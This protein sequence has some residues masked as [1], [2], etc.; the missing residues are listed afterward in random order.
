MTPHPP[1]QNPPPSARRQ[2]R[3][4]VHAGPQPAS[5]TPKRPATRRNRRRLVAVLAAA[6]VVAAGCSIKP[7][8]TV[9]A[10]DDPAPGGAAGGLGDDAKTPSPDTTAPAGPGGQAE[11][12][13]QTIDPQPGGPGG[14]QAGG[15]DSGSEQPSEGGP[16]TENGDGD[17][18]GPVAQTG[19]LIP[20]DDVPFW[21]LVTGRAVR[22]QDGNIT[23]PGGKYG[24]F[25][26]EPEPQWSEVLNE[27]LDMCDD[28]DAYAAARRRRLWPG[29]EIEPW[30]QE[31][32]SSL[33]FSRGVTCGPG[34]RRYVYVTEGGP[35]P[36]GTSPQDAIERLSN[37]AKNSPGPKDITGPPGTPL[38][39]K[40]YGYYKVESP[41][42]EVV[43]LPESVTVI[44]GTIRGLIQNRSRTQWARD[45]TVT[46]GGQQWR[47]PLT[48]QPEEAAPFEIPNWAGTTD[49]AAIELQVTA[50]LSPAVDISRAISFVVINDWF[51]TW[52]EYLKQKFPTTAIPDP[53]DGDFVYTEAVMQVRVPTS[54][55]ELAHQINSQTINDL[56]AYVA[57]LE[58]PGPEAKPVKVTEVTEITPYRYIYETPIQTYEVTRLP[59]TREPYLQYSF[60]IGLD[61]R[62]YHLIWTGG[63]Q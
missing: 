7:D 23:Y 46:A 12:V 29:E 55:P 10:G 30:E 53:P 54:H 52:D 58:D 18:V 59:N 45:A 5:D 50:N 60:L 51:G 4:P 43:V 44:D 16:G 13:G 40:M 1:P 19:A 17:P 24:G 57:F 28:N 21:W 22:D 9:T 38:G 34:G 8:T 47:W 32:I 15:G 36:A 25:W 42:E 41:A 27:T 39:Y 3:Q 26:W 11:P 20:G 14:G 31:E 35:G 2:L 56:K 33:R 6:A 48:M 37:R 61:G 63:A 49:P 62:E